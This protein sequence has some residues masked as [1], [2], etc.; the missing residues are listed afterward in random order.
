VKL[1]GKNTGLKAFWPY[2]LC[3]ALLFVSC[4]IENYVYL[5]PVE[6]VTTVGSTSAHVNL[7]NNPSPEFRHYVIFYR[8]Y[9][10]DRSID[11]ITTSNQ[12]DINNALASHY[13]TINPYTVNDNIS[14]SSVGTVFT[15]LKYY[16]LHVETN[17]SGVPTIVSM[18]Q[19]LSSSSSGTV[20]LIF[21]NEGPSLQVNSPS[22]ELPLRRSAVGFT[23][24]PNRTFF[25]ST[26]SG[27]LSDESR[28]SENSNTDVER[29]TTSGQYTYV[30]LYIAATGIDSNFSVVYSRPKHIGIFRLP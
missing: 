21:A 1:F 29:N 13:N 25:N 11:G 4:G 7:P 30:S 22:A 14:P 8:I 12:R 2:I 19:I 6:Y 17:S 16:Q 10:S 20:D 5:E 9:I 28:I 15:S 23:P 24:S 26:G 3:C 18:D 27:S